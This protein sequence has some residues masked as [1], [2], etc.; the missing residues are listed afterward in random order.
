MTASDLRVAFLT[1]MIPPYHKALYELLTRRFREF[2]FF[3][4]TPMEANRPWQPEW[5]GLNVTTQKCLTFK[6]TWKHASGFKEP[7]AVHF[8]IDT[9]SQLAKF[10]PDVIV[11]IEMGFRTALALAYART[12]RPCRLL[13]WSEITP[14]TEQGRG[15][16]RGLFRRLL[17]PRADGFLSLGPGGARYVASLGADTRRIFKI[18]YSTSLPQFLAIPWE[19]QGAVAARLLFSGQ[20]IER[21]G[22]APFL[23]T[24]ALWGKNHPE[25]VVEFSIVGDG[26][27]L[28]A[29]RALPMPPN[30]KLLFIGPLEYNQLPAAYAGAGIFV[31]PTLADTWAVVVNEA[32]AAGMPVLGSLSSQAVEEMVEDGKTGWT[33]RPGTPGEMYGALDRALACSVEEL[34]KMRPA[35]RKRAQEVTPE[36]AAAVF[37]RA[38]RVVTGRS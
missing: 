27:V 12:H 7:V 21:K 6:R 35:A 22:L 2:R 11:S 25:R 36:S 4:S 26:P 8:P 33:F 17:V 5:S 32:M 20:L 19:R 14:L 1:N 28:P 31:L 38:L 29:L 16:L 15:A 34:N 18:T 13:I 24:L 23:E 30:V 10:K 3:I 9:F 37:E